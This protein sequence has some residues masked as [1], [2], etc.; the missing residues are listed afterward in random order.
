LDWANEPWVKLYTRSTVDDALLSWEARALWA[1]IFQRLDRSGVLAF[2]RHGWKGVA[3]VVG[4]PVDVVERAAPELLADGRIIEGEG[5][6]VAPNYI[7][8]Q[9]SRS[10]NAQR[11]R[12]SREKR[13][14]VALLPAPVTD[15]DQQGD[16]ESQNVT[17]E[18][19]NVTSSHTVSQHVTACHDKKRVE[20]SREEEKRRDK[21]KVGTS[22]KPALSDNAL[23]AAS[24]LRAKIV[25]RSPTCAAARLN[26]DIHQAKWAK[27]LDLL[28]NRDG[29][30]WADIRSS[31]D[32]LHEAENLFVV[33]SADSL[34]KK[35]DSIQAN[36]RNSKPAKPKAS[37]LEWPDDRILR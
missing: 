25:E 32:W 14:A 16:T 15:C 28:N 3:V 37:Q 23:R 30:S 35:W 9:A 1:A 17:V 24:Y 8:A 2:G 4:M 26:W 27:T 22:D 21:S 10:S 36:R 34:R 5:C 20:E 29:A 7:D 33:Q 18:S 12:D 11:Q 13:R 31:I 19:Q 6:I